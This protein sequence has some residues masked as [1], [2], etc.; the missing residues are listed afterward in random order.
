MAL[1]FGG[2]ALSS[3]PQSVVPR[4]HENLLKMQVLR[5]HPRPVE[6]ET[7]GE[8]CHTPLKVPS[9]RKEVCGFL[10][11]ECSLLTSSEL[12]LSAFPT[13]MLTS[14]KVFQQVILQ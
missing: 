8:G 11:G 1:R 6:S 7:L 14:N 9:Y 12:I 10:W 13:F 2:L 4:Q 3:S 5:L